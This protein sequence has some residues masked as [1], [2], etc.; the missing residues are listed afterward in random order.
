MGQEEFDKY[1]REQDALVA[2][3]R[4]SR[5]GLFIEAT[6][7]EAYK[8][9]TDAATP[10]G[11]SITHKLL[12]MNYSELVSDAGILAHELGHYCILPRKDLDVLGDQYYPKIPKSLRPMF[13]NVIEDVRDNLTIRDSWGIA[14]GV[15]QEI[16]QQFLDR[17]K[18]EA[19]LVK[20]VLMLTSVIGLTDL[21]NAL[22]VVGD[23]IPQD[24]GL[25]LQVMEKML[26]PSTTGPAKF[27][28]G[29][30]QGKALWKLLVKHHKEQEQ[31]QQQSQQQSKQLSDNTGGTQRPSGQS[32]SQTETSSE[33]GIR[34]FGTGDPKT[35]RTN[36]GATPGSASAAT[37]KGKLKSKRFRG[38]SM[39]SS[40]GGP[41]ETLDSSF[42]GKFRLGRDHDSSDA[43]KPHWSTIRVV[44]PDKTTSARAVFG[45]GGKNKTFTDTGSGY[46]RFDRLLTDGRIFQS[47]GRTTGWFG[48]TI[49]LD[50]SGSMEL[51]Y[52]EVWELLKSAPYKTTIASYQGLLIAGNRENLYILA[53]HGKV[54]TEEWVEDHNICGGRN[55]ADLPA[56]EWLSKQPKPRIWISDG[57]AHAINITWPD[58]RVGKPVRA[59]MLTGDIKRIRSVADT[60]E[61][62]K[63]KCKRKDLLYTST[64]SNHG[65]YYLENSEERRRLFK[66]DGVK[67]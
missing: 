23:S 6:T 26:A 8:V 21:K 19:N 59:A 42:R 11:I 58:T 3:V 41:V 60:L 29:V 2:R 22:E 47:V 51:H 13:T 36:W 64:P 55:I 9:T 33:I 16:I 7:K 45:M 66:R 53:R 48:G 38:Q 32:G 12:N 14:Q 49:L 17:L 20:R 63:S 54:A 46:L 5:R 37:G 10:P 27:S 44:I 30:L 39:T 65:E 25:M 52:S 18:G 34:T 28:T 43:D 50:T 4:N 56:L 15:N 1:K 40:F 24:I 57:L 67:E 31:Q 62:F 35:G 61:W